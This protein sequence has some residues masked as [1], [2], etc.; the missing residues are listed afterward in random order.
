MKKRLVSIVAAVTAAAMALSAGVV[1]A[2][3]PPAA[4]PPAAPPPAAPPPAAP[5]VVYLSLGDSLGVGV[6]TSQLAR[7]G[8]TNTGYAQHLQHLLRG[9]AHGGVDAFVNLA[10]SGETTTSFVQPGGQLAA[11]LG[12]IGHPSDVSVITLSLG[13]N[14]LLGLV[15]GPCAAPL[16]PA[17][18]AAIQQALATVAANYPPILGAVLQ[19]AG[20]D[21]GGARLVVMTLYNPFSGTGS[22]YDAPVDRVLLG[23]DLALD[24]AANLANPANAGLNDIIACSAQSAGVAVANVYPLFQGKGAVLTHIEEN[25]IHPTDA[26][27]TRIFEAFREALRD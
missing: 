3:P 12:V 25:D 1:G 23:N 2:A 26:G 16:S 18:Q 14:D 11:A 22:V 9:A 17:C 20:Q 24:C 4:P 8:E 27:Y 19:A 21:P 13:G 15:F 10:T 6:G 5:P 7:T